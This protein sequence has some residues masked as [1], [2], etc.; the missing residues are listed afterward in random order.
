MGQYDRFIKTAKRLI[1]K[2]GETCTWIVPGEKPDDDTPWN[3]EP[4][5]ATEYPVK[6]AF[7]TSGGSAMETLAK[8][9]NNEVTFGN[10]IGYM[11]AVVFTPDLAHTIRR[12]NGKI[13]TIQGIDEINPNGQSVLFTIKATQ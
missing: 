13:L 10:V 5:P 4:G 7:F 1:A 3:N 12:A 8:A 6:I 2:Y 11:P 9:I